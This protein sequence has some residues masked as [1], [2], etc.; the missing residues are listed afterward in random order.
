MVEK[1]K[2]F[3]LKARKTADKAADKALALVGSV[4]TVGA[5]AVMNASAA[6]LET[7]ISS[8]DTSILLDG[9]FAV[10]P[11]VLTVAL[12]ILGAKIAINFLFGAVKG[13]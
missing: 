3:A 6:D 11:V 5:A 4:G 8:L 10:L 12:P 13:A 1:I 2:A 9:F 7:T